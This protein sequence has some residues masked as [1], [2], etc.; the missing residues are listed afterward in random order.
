MGE[1]RRLEVRR[2][3]LRKILETHDS[4]QERTQLKKRV[5]ARAQKDVSKQQLVIER[6]NNSSGWASHKL[7]YMLLN[8]L[9]PARDRQCRP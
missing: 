5:F 8:E 6:S 7:L 4:R 2:S 3:P 9:A 1:K